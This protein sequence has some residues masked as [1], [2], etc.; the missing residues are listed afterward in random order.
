[1]T[2]PA[3]VEA[4]LLLVCE[5]MREL[6]RKYPEETGRFMVAN[7]LELEPR[8]IVAAVL[9]GLP[10][11]EQAAE[12]IVTILEQIEAFETSLERNVH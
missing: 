6:L 8:E 7:L 10:P 1:M 3:A 11:P 4:G 9:P 2:S 12:T 5:R